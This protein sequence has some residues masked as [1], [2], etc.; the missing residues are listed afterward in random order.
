MPLQ[1]PSNNSTICLVA[2]LLLLALS[3]VATDFKAYP[4][5]DDYFEK[6]YFVNHNNREYYLTIS[7]KEQNMLSISLTTSR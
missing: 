6:V 5:G 1:R 2:I 4:L 7:C 3:C